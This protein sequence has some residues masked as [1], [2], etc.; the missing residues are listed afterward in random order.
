MSAGD[1]RMSSAT[2]RARARTRCG[3]GTS[4][5]ETLCSVVFSCHATRT[6]AD[7]S[8]RYSTRTSMGGVSAVACQVDDS[9]A[10]ASRNWRSPRG[11]LGQSTKVSV[12]AA[13]VAARHVPDDESEARQRAAAFEAESRRRLN[14]IALG[15]TLHFLESSAGR[16]AARIDRCSP[17]RCVQLSS[18]CLRL[19]KTCP[20]IFFQGSSGVGIEANP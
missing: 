1:P 17:P 9:T 14:S 20:C 11:A 8:Q 5:T 15:P 2:A 19:D 6:L 10:H 3:E 4:S 7:S 13:P 18:T 16:V 12:G